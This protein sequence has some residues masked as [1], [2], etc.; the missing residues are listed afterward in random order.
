VRVFWSRW[1]KRG[2][3]RGTDNT[4]KDLWMS[5]AVVIWTTASSRP[6]NLVEDKYCEMDL[7]RN[8]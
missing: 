4:K 5:A 1:G 6:G 3:P 8:E 2:N 7:Q